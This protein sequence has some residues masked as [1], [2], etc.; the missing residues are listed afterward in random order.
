MYMWRAYY[1]NPKEKAFIQS[2][3]VMDMIPLAGGVDPR[4]SLRIRFIA[5]T[6]DNSQATFEVSRYV[7]QR[8]VSRVYQVKTGEAIGAKEKLQDGDVD[9]STRY[10]LQSVVEKEDRITSTSE[11]YAS[12]ASR[13]ATLKAEPKSRG[14]PETHQ[15]LLDNDQYVPLPK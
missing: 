15:L 6:P 5:A 11:V 14:I 9:F 3:P 7:G 2:A 1:R 12:R 4:T 8:H 10:V 13:Q